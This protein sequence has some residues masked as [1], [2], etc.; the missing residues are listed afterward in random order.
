MGRNGSGGKMFPTNRNS[1]N[2]VGKWKKNTVHIQG[3]LSN[4]VPQSARYVSGSIVDMQLY[5]SSQNSV[6]GRSETKLL[7]SSGGT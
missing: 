4:W 6:P 2:K 7:P 1:M 3:R 5:V